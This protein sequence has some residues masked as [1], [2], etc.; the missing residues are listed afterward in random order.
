M[1]LPPLIH[2]PIFISTTLAIREACNKALLCASLAA[3]A[4]EVIPRAAQ[5]ASEQ[6][7]W[8]SSLAD[9]DPFLGLPLLVGLTALMNVEI[10]AVNRE[11]LATL[12]ERNLGAEES[13]VTMSKPRQSHDFADP[14]SPTLAASKSDI[15]LRRSPRP[16]STIPSI[17]RRRKMS[18]GVS[19]HSQPNA[20]SPNP[21]SALSWKASAT[22][23]S[24]PNKSQIR[25][26]VIT[27]VLRFGSIFFVPIAAMAPVV[28]FS[29]GNR[30]NG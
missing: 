30:S 4:D 5:L 14:Q 1:L 6:L 22:K 2:L 3:E 8:C 13:S 17:L 26:R 16:T 7:L 24:V 18:T 27:N 15:I 19:D 21:S 20:S 9:S 12:N 25:S 11:R 23:A 28:S 10:Q 29:N